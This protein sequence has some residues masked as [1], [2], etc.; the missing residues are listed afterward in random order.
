MSDAHCSWG[1]VEPKTGVANHYAGRG[2]RKIKRGRS[3]EQLDVER[4]IEEVNFEKV[5][6]DEI[7]RVDLRTRVRR[8]QY[9]H[10]VDITRGSLGAG[11]QRR[12]A[13]EQSEQRSKLHT[14]KLN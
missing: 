14:T 1:G 2:I 12:R 3:V 9:D 7:G 10:V 11:I 8:G 5:I 4:G 13:T 6:I